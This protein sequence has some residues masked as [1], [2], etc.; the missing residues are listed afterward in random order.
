LKGLDGASVLLCARDGETFV[1]KR[2]VAPGSNPRLRKQAIKQRLFAAQELSFP[3]VRAIGK[4]ESGQAYFEMDYVPSC[5]VADAIVTDRA[6]D[7]EALVAVVRDM[8]WR[9]RA[10]LSPTIDANGFAAKILD[11]YMKL[12]RSDWASPYRGAIERLFRR[13]SREDWS[14]IPASPAHGDLTLENILVPEVGSFCFIDCDEPFA[15]SYWLDLAKLFQDIHGHWCLRNEP[16]ADE[17]SIARLEELGEPFYALAVEADPRLPARLGHL[18]ALSLYRTLPYA[19]GP[20]AIGYAVEAAERV[21][22]R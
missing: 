17:D 13:L 11:V 20:E 7:R 18:A 19:K 9:F 15:T 2:A 5:T 14:G 22:D 1:R 10:C 6:Y 21:L 16:S 8:V 4:D 3:S 12:E